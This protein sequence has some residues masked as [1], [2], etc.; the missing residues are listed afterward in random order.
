MIKRVEVQ[1]RGVFQKTLGKY[2][3]GDIVQIA[4]RMGKVA[5]S[6]G[7]YSDAP[8][9][10]GIP[11]KYFAFVSPDLSEAELEAECGS[12]YNADNVDVSVVV[13]DAMAQGVEPWGWHG[14]RPVN[15]K[16]GHNAFLHGRF[17]GF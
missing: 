8:E 2:I 13:D 17:V 5:F 10:N 12:S 14:I 15:E 7:R 3:G 11:C 9:R 6:N 16:V 1:Y 4:S